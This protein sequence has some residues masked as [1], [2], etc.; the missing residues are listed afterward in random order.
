MA[1]KK[2]LLQGY[3]GIEYETKIVEMLRAKLALEEKQKLWR[4]S[5]V[6]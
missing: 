4:Q 1:L 3:W 5:H 2:M 6:H